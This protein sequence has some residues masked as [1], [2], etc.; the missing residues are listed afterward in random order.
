MLSA[1]TDEPVAVGVVF[2]VNGSDTD[3][4]RVGI[5]LDVMGV[6]AGQVTGGSSGR[7]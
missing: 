5:E 4:V 2:V 6:D 1:G 3:L 7:S